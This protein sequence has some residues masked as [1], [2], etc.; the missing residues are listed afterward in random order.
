MSAGVGWG[1]FYGFVFSFVPVLVMSLAAR[2]WF[3]G[4]K[5][6]LIVVCIGLLLALPN[7][8]TLWVTSGTGSGSHAGERT[9][10]VEAPF[11]RAWSVVGVVAGVALALF[12][13]IGLKVLKERRAKNKERE[14]NLAERERQLDAKESA[15]GSTSAN[16]SATPSAQ[17]GGP[18]S[19]QGSGDGGL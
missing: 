18:D 16:P 14:A 12:I 13:V 7:W 15:L 3:K 19:T 4:W 10:D 9:F 8:L 17:P 5:A 6:K 11:F 1:L 2:P